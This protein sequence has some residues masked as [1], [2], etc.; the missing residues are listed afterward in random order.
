MKK[1]IA[2]SM[3]IIGVGVGIFLLNYLKL[4][5][6]INEIIE[7]DP[8]NAGVDMRA[9]F[10]YYVDLSTIV[11]N[12]KSLS[13]GKNSS[14]VFR[15]LLQLSQRGGWL[16]NRHVTLIYQ[17]RRL[18]N[19]LQPQFELQGKIRSVV[20]QNQ[21]NGGVQVLAYYAG[22]SDP[23]TLIFDLQDVSLEKSMADVFRVFLQSAEKLQEH[24]FQHVDLAF[25][26]EPKFRMA[27]DY[28]T[29]LGKEYSWQNPVY[30]IRTFPE[31]ILNMDG[32]RAFPEWT[33][34]L[35]G[36]VGKQ[37]DDLTD[38]HK[39]WWLDQKLKEAPHAAN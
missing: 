36:V 20:E 3:V 38:F 26:G 15:V 18:A 32:T 22:L 9:H 7:S 25:R 14:D 4:Q 8:T 33:G 28:F 11:F 31:S 5:K 17:D 6:P 35:L 19:I 10:A 30:T 29:K 23:A 16:Q 39:K 34:G 24:T 2:L 27:G 1:L 37:F 13:K 21:R 12:V